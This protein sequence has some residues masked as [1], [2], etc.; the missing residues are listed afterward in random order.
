MAK[1]DM[2]AITLQQAY[3]GYGVSEE[4]G[5]TYFMKFFPR[6]SKFNF[7]T[8]L[9]SQMQSYP[10]RYVL[11]F[12]LSSSSLWLNLPAAEWLN[13]LNSPDVRVD[14]SRT[15]DQV[16][17]FADVEFLSRYVGVDA[18]AFLIDSMNASWSDKEY[19]L[20]YFSKFSYGLVPSPLDDEDLDGLYFVSKEILIS[21]QETLCHDF[22]FARVEWNEG[23]ANE[24]IHDLR[25]RL[26][27]K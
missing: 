16:G 1:T 21:L 27:L 9:K 12:I 15:N 26:G 19:A 20:N 7:G 8:V 14:T 22:G 23:N 6:L 24:Y 2:L 25:N 18:L 13:I 11:D 10:H 3:D 5:I 4:V 17:Q